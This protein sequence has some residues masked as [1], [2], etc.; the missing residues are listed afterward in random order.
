MNA[1]NTIKKAL[2][3]CIYDD[4]LNIL[5][6]SGCKNSNKALQES[7]FSFCGLFVKNSGSNYLQKAIDPNQNGVIL[8]L[9]NQ[10]Y[11]GIESEPAIQKAAIDVFKIFNSKLSLG[12]F[13]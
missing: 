1:K 8:K 7:A 12:S 10:L 2:E 11:I 4:F 6:E 5:I 3:L 9:I 13:V